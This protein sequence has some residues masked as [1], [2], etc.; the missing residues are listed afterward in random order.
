MLF[1]AKASL[2]HLILFADGQK[3]YNGRL[4]EIPIKETVILN[5][6][7][8]FFND[9]EPCHIH[10]NAVRMRLA[11]EILQECQEECSSPGPIL[12]AYA[13]FPQIDSYLLTRGK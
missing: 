12:C 1:K 2:P 5:K 8:H 4:S 7:V 13:D 3:I 9:P 10:R 6:S 11:Q